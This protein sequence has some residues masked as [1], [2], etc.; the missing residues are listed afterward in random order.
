MKLGNWF[1]SMFN[2][3]LIAIPRY[4]ITSSL[5]AQLVGGD[6]NIADVPRELMEIRQVQLTLKGLK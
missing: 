6:I 3:G 4:C 1:P 5:V 2:P